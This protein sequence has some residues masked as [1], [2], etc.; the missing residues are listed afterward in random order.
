MNGLILRFKLKRLILNIKTAIRKINLNNIIK[1]ISTDKH[2]VT[3]ILDVIDKKRCKAAYIGFWNN[4]N[5]VFNNLSIEPLDSEKVFDYVFIWGL[6]YKIQFEYFTY[7][8]KFNL[9]LFILEDG[10]IKSIDTWVNSSCEQKYRDGVSFTIDCRA[11]YFNAKDISCLELMIN[12]RDLIITEEQKARARKCIDKI[13]ST[14]LTK[15]NHQPIFTPNIGREG[16][17]KVLVVD[18]SYGDLSIDMGLANDKT[19]KIMLQAAIDENPGADIII[20]T[21]PDTLAG[22]GCYYKEILPHDNI[23]IVKDAINPISMIKDVDKVYVCTS[24]FGFEALMCGKEVVVFGIPF[25]AGWGLTNDKQFLQR[26]T[27]KRTL[28]EIFYIAYIMYSFYVN[29]DKK[30]RCEIEEAIEYLLKLRDEYNNKKGL[31]VRS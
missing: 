23:Y 3:C 15:Y 28:E 8:Q 24:Q 16:V 1:K 19:F 5:Y 6:N 11:V 14:H 4:V 18:Q 17:T 22:A 10:F 21:H 26:R 25:Y 27:N 30:C 9:P 31:F 29:P 7:A 13:L 2:Y 12:D 20:K